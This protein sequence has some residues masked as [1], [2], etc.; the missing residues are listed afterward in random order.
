MAERSGFPYCTKWK[1]YRYPL[2]RLSAGYTNPTKVGYFDTAPLDIWVSDDYFLMDSTIEY[3]VKMTAATNDICKSIKRP[4]LFTDGGSGQAETTSGSANPLFK[5]DN[6]DDEVGSLDVVSSLANTISSAGNTQSL[7][8]VIP[9][10]HF[11][12]T[13]TAISEFSTNDAFGWIM[14]SSALD[15]LPKVMDG[16]YTCWYKLPLE[17]TDSV[18]TEIIPNGIANKSM[19]IMWNA[20]R[21]VGKRSATSTYNSQ[22]IILQ[23]SS[24]KVNWVDIATPMDDINMVDGASGDVQNFM[25]VVHWD[26]NA[27]DGHDSRYKRLKILFNAS[28]DPADDIDYHVH[29]YIQINITPN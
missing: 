6:H 5:L 17:S 19:T 10:L 3:V 22:S 28:A 4:R 29:Q 13:H 20:N 25:Q 21:H 26:S 27:I 18:L 9:G 1:N 8:T 15:G 11:G 2:T 16:T 12:F 23:G 7:Y 14:E 24:D